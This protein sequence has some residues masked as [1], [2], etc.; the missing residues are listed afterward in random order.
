MGEKRNT[1][2]F[3]MGKPERKRTLEVQE[4]IQQKVLQNGGYC[5]ISNYVCYNCNLLFA[6][7][8]GIYSLKRVQLGA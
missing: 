4:V 8:S 7:H 3:F 2:I 6:F 5:T 1:H